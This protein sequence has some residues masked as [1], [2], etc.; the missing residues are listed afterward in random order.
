[1]NCKATKIDFDNAAD[2]IYKFSKEVFA[3]NDEKKKSHLLESI[4]YLMNPNSS[5]KRPLEDVDIDSEAKRI[6]LMAPKVPNEIWMKIMSYLKTRDMFGKFALV[7]KH[8]HGLTLDPSAVKYLHI[9]EVRNKTRSKVL[10]KNW[11]KIVKRSRTLK[12]LKIKAHFT[13]LDWNGLIEETLKSNPCLKSLNIN[14]L[15]TSEKMPSLTLS[16]GVFEALK[17]AKGLQCYQSLNVNVT[18]EFY[19]EICKL[20]LLKKF[21][22]FNSEIKISAALVKRLALSENP[23]EDFKVS[24]ILALSK[25][26]VSNVIDILYEEK[27]GTIKTVDISELKFREYY[28]LTD[29]FDHGECHPLP[30]F[31]KCKNITKVN[32]VLHKHDL[33]LISDLPKLEDLTIHGS[34]MRDPTYFEPF[35]KMNLSSLK[36]LEIANNHANIV[37]VLVK[38]PFPSLKRLYVNNISVLLD[39]LT[40]ISEKTIEALICSIPSLHSCTLYSKL[41]RGV[42][43]LN[44]E[45]EKKLQITNLK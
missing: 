35:H 25:E 37:E 22:V 36:Y 6:K 39:N 28:V 14:Y 27:K 26:E 19:I 23:I 4:K 13:Y 32:E 17:L 1:M 3:G 30:K 41:Y 2:E 8:F 29:N 10:F 12:E 7:N 9:A 44:L 31:N 45:A 34:A 15:A 18:H 11:M 40:P 42:L 33:E 5:L 21:V 38:I 43:S 20:K 16:P 24:K